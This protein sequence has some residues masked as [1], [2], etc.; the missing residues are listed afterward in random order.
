MKFYKYKVETDY[1]PIDLD[2]ISSEFRLIHLLPNE[3]K[4]GYNQSYIAIF[5]REIEDKK[6]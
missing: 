5:E 3:K 6:Q 1:Y 2:Y 4:E